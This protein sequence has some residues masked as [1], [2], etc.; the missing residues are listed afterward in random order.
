MYLTCPVE[1]GIHFGF[2]ASAT[3]S[4]VKNMGGLTLEKTWILDPEAQ[5]F[6]L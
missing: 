6:D 3:R 4:P 1:R 5:N 2:L